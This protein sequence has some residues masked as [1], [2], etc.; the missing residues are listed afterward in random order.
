MK[1]LT[2][3]N[4]TVACRGTYRGDRT[5]LSKEVSGATIDS[6]KVKKD[7]LFVA[8]DGERF[9]ANQFIPDTLA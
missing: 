1:N 4:I 2:L 9:N 7:N 5:L 8:I 3:E 6:R